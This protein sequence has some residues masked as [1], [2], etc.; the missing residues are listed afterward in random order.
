M[1]S[2]VHPTRQKLS[3]HQK[4]LPF[5]AVVKDVSS[6]HCPSA[7]SIQLASIRIESVTP[8]KDHDDDVVFLVSHLGQALF[9]KV[10]EF[11]T[12]DKRCILVLYWYF[13]GN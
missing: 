2:L 11:I 3:L 12:I 5:D 8:N 4:Y 6:C 9:K 7:T 10:L 13:D 1:I